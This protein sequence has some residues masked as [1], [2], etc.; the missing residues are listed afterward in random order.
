M[1]P[2][3]L[4]Q[5]Q[6]TR[7]AVEHGVGWREIASLFESYV[8]VDTYAGKHRQLLAPQPWHSSVARPVQA[9]RLGLDAGSPRA[10]K[11]S[12]LRFG[13][14]A[15]LLRI[16]G[17]LLVVLSVPGSRLLGS[18][19]L[20]RPQLIWAWMA[21]AKGQTRRGESWQSPSSTIT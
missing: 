17:A 11:L 20:L 6:G 21:G 9:H 8:V 1:C 16:R 5:M 19:R 18:T 10:Q 12:Q 14:H 4:F 15:T 13:R 3:D 2:F 7:E